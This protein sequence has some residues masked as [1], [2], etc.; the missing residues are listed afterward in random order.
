MFPNHCSSTVCC[1][2]Q[3]IWHWYLL[4]FIKSLHCIKDSYCPSISRKIDWSISSCAFI[5]C[6]NRIYPNSSDSLLLRWIRL[7]AVNVWIRKG[8]QQVGL[9]HQSSFHQCVV[10]LYHC[11][12]AQHAKLKKHSVEKLF[13][14]FLLRLATLVFTNSVLLWRFCH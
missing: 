4:F 1:T 2:L 12:E 11:L 8:F 14:L 9:T 3:Y 10:E 13:Q 6:I 5:L 7:F